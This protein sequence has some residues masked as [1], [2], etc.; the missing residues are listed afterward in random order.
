MRNLFLLFIITFI[1][2]L[3]LA[4][5]EHKVLFENG[6]I[7]EYGSFDDNNDK[8]GKWQY[9]LRMGYYAKL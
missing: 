4:Q 7:K 8:I 1:Y 6:N 2:D 5:K 9:F 3:A